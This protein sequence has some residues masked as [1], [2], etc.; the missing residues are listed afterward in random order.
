MEVNEKEW[1]RFAGN[2]TNGLIHGW[3]ANVAACQSEW[4]GS[5]GL[6]VG[7]IR[8][9]DSVTGRAREPH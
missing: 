1:K 8:P 9:S 5:G 7:S 3:R 6:V 4:P 2:E